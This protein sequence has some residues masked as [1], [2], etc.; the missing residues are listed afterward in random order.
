MNDQINHT[1][2][3]IVATTNYK[4]LRAAFAIYWSSYC[5]TCNGVGGSIYYYDPSPGGISLGAGWME[6][7]NPCPDC[8]E[9]GLCPRCGKEFDQDSEEATCPHCG[10]D[11]EKAIRDHRYVS[12]TPENITDQCLASFGMHAIPAEPEC[13]CFEQMVTTFDD[14]EDLYGFE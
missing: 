12:L 1:P 6:D 8:I 13:F 4:R 5:T 3:C 2:S 14:F 10:W 9:Q 11:Q 7:M